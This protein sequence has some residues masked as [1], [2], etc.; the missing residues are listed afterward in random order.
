M[1]LLF[2]QDI[3]EIDFAQ[4]ENQL[5]QSRL[6]NMDVE[7]AIVE[8][9]EEMIA[10]A[11]THIADAE[12]AMLKVENFTGESLSV[13]RQHIRISSDL[14]IKVPIIT[15]A[16]NAGTNISGVVSTANAS[17]LYNDT[18]WREGQNVYISNRALSTAGMVHSI[19]VMMTRELRDGFFLGRSPGQ[20][21]VACSA[22]SIDGPI[23]LTSVDPLRVINMND[24][25][26]TYVKIGDKIDLHNKALHT[27]FLEITAS[28]IDGSADVVSCKKIAFLEATSGVETLRRAREVFLG[29]ELMLSD[30]AIT[31]KKDSNIISIENLSTVMSENHAPSNGWRINDATR[32]GDLSAATLLEIKDGIIQNDFIEEGKVGITKVEATTVLDAVIERITSIGACD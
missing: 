2:N 20:E 22:I 27:D 13:N 8:I 10:K 19:D 23:N 17:G 4:I 3:E 21:L 6:D 11:E 30:D 15:I 18:F 12:M 1:G 31:P 28:E 9:M 24:A 7:I 29:Q 26:R 5:L 25:H 16:K 14:S 32:E